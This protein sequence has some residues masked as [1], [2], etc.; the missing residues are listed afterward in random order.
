MARIT[1]KELQE[2]IKKSDEIIK[3]Q[4]DKIQEL[5]VQNENILNNKDCV[6]KAEYEALLKQFENLQSN[7]KTFKE[8]YEHWKDKSSKL[9]NKCTELEKK[10]AKTDPKHNERG[11]G[12]KRTLTDEQLE[13]VQELH[14][15]GKS[16]GAIAKEVGISK[17][18]VYK[19]IN[20]Q[21][22]QRKGQEM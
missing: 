11:A 6:S 10:L 17:A 5:Q 8:L 9:I 19:L 15:Q 2:H 21:Q 12:R 20:K 14:Q 3:W 13:K 18:Y 16:Y 22:D 1:I 4:Q 7:H